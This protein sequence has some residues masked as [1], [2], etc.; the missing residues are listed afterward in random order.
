M[1]MLL[2]HV[3]LCVYDDSFEKDLLG[4]VVVVVEELVEYTYT[5]PAKHKIILPPQ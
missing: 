4:V 2:F 5:L 1:M 3:K